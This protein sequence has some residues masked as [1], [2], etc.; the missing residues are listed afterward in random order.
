[1]FRNTGDVESGIRCRGVE[2]RERDR[3][4]SGIEVFG[5][6]RATIQTGR[7]ERSEGCRPL[8]AREPDDPG[9]MAGWEVQDLLALPLTPT[10]SP[11]RPALMNS[12]GRSCI[13]VSGR[14]V[15]MTDLLAVR[16]RLPECDWDR[17]PND[18]I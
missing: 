18:G 14:V 12:E 7:A 17:D 2:N 9:V 4:G 15:S 3:Y 10:L 1:M 5:A 11:R 13:Q 6:E 16:C 8:S